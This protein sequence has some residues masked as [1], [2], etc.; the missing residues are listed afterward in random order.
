MN[1]HK[2]LLG[3]QWFE[4]SIESHLEKLRVET[5]ERRTKKWK[6]NK[7]REFLAL[8]TVE[9]NRA[10]RRRGWILDELDHCINCKTGIKMPVAQS[11]LKEELKKLKGDE[12]CLKFSYQKGTEELYEILGEK[13]PE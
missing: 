3:P 4:R 6:E 1:K 9:L 2:E 8:V 5:P 7:K 13:V 11:L 10:E 12:F